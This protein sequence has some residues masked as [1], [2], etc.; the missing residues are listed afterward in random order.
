M[1]ITIHPPLVPY[2]R[3]A[4]WIMVD[5][6]FKVVHGSTNEFKVVVWDVSLNCCKLF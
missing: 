5:T 6:T 2:I 3:T 1:I 4:Q